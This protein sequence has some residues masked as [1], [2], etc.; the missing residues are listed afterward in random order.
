M[1][2]EEG[3]GGG[4]RGGIEK[5]GNKQS[6]CKTPRESLTIRNLLYYVAGEESSSSSS[7]TMACSD[8][9]IRTYHQFICS[10]PI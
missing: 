7:V 6:D 1:N 9:G 2:L 10:V 4:G 5:P 3:S 8:Y